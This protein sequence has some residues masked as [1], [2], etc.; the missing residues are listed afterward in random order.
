MGKFRG[1]L[2]VVCLL[3]FVC[4]VGPVSAVDGSALNVSVNDT[5]S[6]NASLCQSDVTVGSVS[7]PDPQ[8]LRTGKSYSI[9][10]PQSMIHP[11]W[12]GMLLR[13]NRVIT[14]KILL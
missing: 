6:M 12:M 4:F 8:N 3:F 2:I 5:G 11:R 1:L 7:L 10:R 9:S 14:L 13:L